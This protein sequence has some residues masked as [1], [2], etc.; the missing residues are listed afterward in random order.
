[1]YSN[2]PYYLTAYGLAVKRGFRGTEDEWLEFLTAYGLAKAKGFEG[3]L[4]EWL[5]SLNGATF[6]PK[7]E[8]GILSW[9][10]GKGLPNPESVD[11]HALAL[12]GIG[13][14]IPVTIPPESWEEA[15]EQEGTYRYFFDILHVRITSAMKPCLTLEEESLTVAASCGMCPVCKSYA[16]FVRVKAVERPE[17]EI[18]ATLYLAAM[19]IPEGTGQEYELP[20]ASEKVLGGIKGSDTIRIDEDGTAHAVTACNDTV[21][22]SGEVIQLLDEIFGSATNDISG[23]EP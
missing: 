12:G 16:G 9:D 19:H 8:D 23:E 21:A 15:E 5:E 11:L 2:P 13:R 17:K 3:T 4:E 6:V 22:D 20:V 7:V 14:I 10:N 1:M 18:Q